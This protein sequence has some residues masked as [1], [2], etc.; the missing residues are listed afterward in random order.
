MNENQQ[1]I[2]EI[3]LRNKVKGKYKF[4]YNLSKH[5][6]FGI[7]GNAEIF[8]IPSSLEE[9][10]LVLTAK[11]EDIG[12]TVIGLGSNIIIRDGGISGLVIRLGNE[13]SNIY[14]DK[15]IVFAGA[16]VQDK[17]LSK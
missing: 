9:L 10:Q 4:D 13:F 14:H 12:V 5:S 2:N 16:A 7:G 8:Y 1:I 17:V 11:E 15:N 3:F 6:W